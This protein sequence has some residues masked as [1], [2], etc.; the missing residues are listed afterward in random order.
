MPDVFVSYSRR[1]SEFVS[2]LAEDLKARG[3][4]V[5]VDVE[6]IR[7]AEVFPLALRRAIEGSDAFV[8]VISPDSVASPYCEQ[9]VAHA[10]ELNKRIVPVNLRPVPDAQIPAE[11]R[12]RNWIPIESG[13]G[14]GSGDG[15]TALERVLAAI[16]TD[17]DW[18]REH[19]RLTVRALEWDSSGREGS[20]LLRGSD[21]AAA[22]RWLHESAGKD[23]GPTD[24]EREF[25]LAARQAAGR[26]QRTFA[27]ASLAV[28]VIALGL[29]VFALISRSHAVTAETS[30]KAQALA[31]ESQVEQS[32]NPELAV[33]L[34][35]Q[36]VRT[37]PTYGPLGSMFALR[38]ALDASAIRYRVHPLNPGVQGCGGPGVAYDP[39]PNSNLL[40]VGL[41]DGQIL[42]A[43]A[44]TGA[45][46]RTVSTGRDGAIF[47]TYTTGGK[48]LL[49]ATTDRVEIRNPTTGTIVR[50]SSPTGSDQDFCGRP[51]RPP[52]IH[53]RRH[54]IRRRD[55]DWLFRRCGD[56]HRFC[57]R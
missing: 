32:A 23:P 37:K 34:G 28:A 50:E 8:F 19:T 15:D 53:Q 6:G 54:W 52:R 24:L 20:S 4:D 29:L 55:L 30:A 33:L 1:D 57:R 16:D 41:C 27:G 12:F 48:E 39:A 31:A 40:A 26:R 44:T 56:I 36:A 3:K 13:N 38:G 49:S 11:I 22:E 25:I 47:I 46:E 5:W 10:A 9:E 14:A 51:A 17:L 43:N 7:D 2:Q 21:L 45:V 35:M 18:E 42:L